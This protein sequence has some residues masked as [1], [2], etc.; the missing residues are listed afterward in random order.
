M[1]L[2]PSVGLDI[3]EIDRIARLAERNGKFL[4]RI[5]TD[6]EIRYC[7]GKAK[8]WQHF[9]VRF[10]AKE[11]VWKALGREGLALR[12]ISVGRDESG[13]PHVMLHGRPAPEIGI[14]LT[15]SEKFAAA[16]VFRNGE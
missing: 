7:R 4:S 8:Q 9:A 10:A 1:S 3:V 2:P 13:R 15:H 5:F 16:V 14:S 6:D 12:D 11:A